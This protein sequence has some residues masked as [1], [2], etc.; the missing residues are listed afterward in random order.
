MIGRVIVCL[1]G[2]TKAHLLVSG[3]RKADNPRFLGA[4]LSHT[5]SNPNLNFSERQRQN[6][7]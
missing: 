7:F 1:E 4:N 5:I 2:T 6:I 3:A